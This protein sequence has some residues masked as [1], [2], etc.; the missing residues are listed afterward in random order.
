M[1]VKDAIGTIIIEF[2]EE[3]GDYNRDFVIDSKYISVGAKTSKNVRNGGTKYLI[4]PSSIISIG[5]EAFSNWFM[6]KTF[7][8]A[9][10]VTTYGKRCFYNC[11]KLEFFEAGKATKTISEEAFYECASLETIYLGKNITHIGK[12][13][14]SKISNSA[15]IYCEHLS[16]PSTFDKEWTDVPSK[17]IIWGYKKGSATTTSASKP[18]ERPQ[19]KPTPVKASTIT[20]QKPSSYTQA[21]KATT[22]TYSSLKKYCFPCK[23]SFSNEYQYCPICRSI[24]ITETEYKK[25]LENERIKQEQENRTKRED[26]L[27]VSNGK[28]LYEVFQKYESI[29]I[30]L[31]AARVLKIVKYSQ[32]EDDFERGLRKCYINN[33]YYFDSYFNRDALLKLYDVVIEHKSY[34]CS[35]MIN[36]VKKEI[37]TVKENLNKLNTLLSQC[38]YINNNETL[39]YGKLASGWLNGGYF[40]ITSR[41]ISTIEERNTGENDFFRDTVY[42]VY[43]HMSYDIDKYYASRGIESRILNEL[44]VASND[45][46]IKYIVFMYE[47]Q[48]LKKYLGEEIIRINEYLRT[49]NKITVR[50]PDIL[51]TKELVSLL[52]NNKVINKSGSRITKA[53]I[54][55]R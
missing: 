37:I 13:A 52:G 30:Y 34:K 45:Y 33:R 23:K 4:I 49:I 22:T 5:E 50:Y 48:L 28:K 26:E 24:L 14:F 9:S 15:K 38:K 47:A 12:R 2:E 10:G 43:K 11:F 39:N 35:D 27:L 19:P 1:K 55:I 7:F 36:D 46:G 31:M 32:Y 6:L 42:R 20:T 16:Q 51:D 29:N 54:T 44:K 40:E 41:S 18:V 3:A 25:E 21:K 53:T 17:N 8:I